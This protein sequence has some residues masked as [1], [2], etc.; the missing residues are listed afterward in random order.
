MKEVVYKVTDA[1]GIHARPAG[2]LVKEAAKFADTKITIS[3]GVKEVDAKRIM[4]LMGLGVKQ[5]Q[6][7]TM[8]FD[9]PG[10]ADAA[11]A[12]ETFL[13]ENL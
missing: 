5:G 2:L 13:K 3:N 6:T 8:T 9:G 11:E 10:E 1:M 4:G 12:I 7:V